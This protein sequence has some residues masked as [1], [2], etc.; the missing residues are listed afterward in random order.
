MRIEKQHVFTAEGTRATKGAQGPKLSKTFPKM[1][2]RGAPIN[3]ASRPL[4]GR[5]TKSKSTTERGKNLSKQ[6]GK[7]LGKVPTPFLVSKPSSS[8]G[9]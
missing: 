4:S 1:F 9:S 7:I 8:R 2:Q 6:V 5:V 3:M